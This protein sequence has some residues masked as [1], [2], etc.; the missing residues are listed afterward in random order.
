MF[1]RDVNNY[2]IWYKMKCII[3][4]NFTMDAVYI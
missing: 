3:Y 1:E 2:I 4:L